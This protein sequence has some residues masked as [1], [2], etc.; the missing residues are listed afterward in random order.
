[1]RSAE[2]AQGD[3]RLIPPC[4]EKEEERGGMMMPVTMLLLGTRMDVVFVIRGTS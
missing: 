3:G 1:M 4:E 2:L